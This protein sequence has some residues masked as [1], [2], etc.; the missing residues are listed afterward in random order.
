MALP[1]DLHGLMA[2]R[3]VLWP[4][5]DSW[6]HEIELK[7]VLRDGFLGISPQAIFVV[8]IDGCL[9]GFLEV[10][11]RSR[12]DGCD[13]GH[14]VA[15]VEGWYVDPKFRRKGVGREL[16]AAAEG[17]GRNQGCREIASDTWIDNEVSQ[18][19]HRKLGFEVVDRCVNY[20]KS[21]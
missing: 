14:P 4:D 11:L 7:S 17:W 13:P 6:E 8:E 16:L 10:S 3:A 15:Y 2:M 9:A 5:S 19:V 18:G 12:A 20:R 21:L 1:T